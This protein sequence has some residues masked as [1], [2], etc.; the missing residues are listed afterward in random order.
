MKSSFLLVLSLVC[1]LRMLNIM[2]IF[3]LKAL[4]KLMPTSIK[5]C[6]EYAP[7]RLNDMP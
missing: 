6:E 7:S 1:N 4:L 3:T 2:L 5:I